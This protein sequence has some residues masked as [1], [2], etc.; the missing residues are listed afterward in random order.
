MAIREY[1]CN[2]CDHIHEIIEPID[3]LDSIRYCIWCG[4]VLTRVEIS[5]STFSLKSG[6]VGWFKDGYSKKTQ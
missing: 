6:G 1:H 2:S 3:E 5:K 4:K